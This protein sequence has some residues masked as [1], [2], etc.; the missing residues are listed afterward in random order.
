MPTENY[1]SRI[2]EQAEP[3]M[4]IIVRLFQM[5]NEEKKKHRRRAELIQAIE[6]IAPYLNIPPE[7]SLYLLELYMLNYRADGDYSD[8]TKGNFN[9]PRKMRGKTTSNTK[10]DLYTVAKLPF[11]G[12][13]LEGYWTKDRRDVPLYQVVSWGWYPIYIFRDDKWYQVSQPYSSSTGRQLSNSNPVEWSEVFETNVY[14][15]TPEEMKMLING[16]TH[17]E[18]MKSKMKS[19]K[20]KESELTKRANFASTW[21]YWGHEAD[22]SDLKIKYKVKSIDLEDDKA[23][24]VVDV[25]DVMKRVGN[26]GIPTTKSEIEN[27]SAESVERAIEGKL[28]GK[29]RDYIGVRYRYYEKL[30]SESRIVFKFNHKEDTPKN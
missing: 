6:N 2:S 30:P 4:P 25:L 28:K 11:R 14:L 10:S 24:V 18:I 19:L 29:L 3:K 16:A 9:D 12:S 1:I 26:K 21:R 5:L 8:L 13:N 7:Y 17:E 23:V 27:V 15:L 22:N 20:K